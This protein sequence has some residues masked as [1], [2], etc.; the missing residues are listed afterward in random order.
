MHIVC[1][2][3]MESL[4]KHSLVKNRFQQYIKDIAEKKSGI[5]AF[6][7]GY[8]NEFTCFF[9]YSFFR[10]T[11]C[12]MESACQTLNN[13]CGILHSYVY[14]CGFFLAAHPILDAGRCT[15]F[16]GDLFY[17]YSRFDHLGSVLLPRFGKS[18]PYFGNVYSISNDAVSA[19]VIDGSS[20]FHCRM[21]S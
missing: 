2:N 1:K 15:G 3:Q 6:A 13:E 10:R 8:F 5:T 20:N 21:G 19:L 12:F 17:L 14:A 18:L 9:T 16:T 7:R 11:P 4:I